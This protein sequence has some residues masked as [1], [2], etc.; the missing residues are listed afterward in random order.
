MSVYPGFG[1]QK[2]IEG[3]LERLSELSKL[4]KKA[5]PD[6]LVEVDGGVTLINAKDIAG[7]GADILVA[8]STVFSHP[9]R[10][11][12]IKLLRG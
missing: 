5:N 2:F 4:A 10:R 12:A 7:A 11:A 9:N 8:G 1:G 3:S 6:I